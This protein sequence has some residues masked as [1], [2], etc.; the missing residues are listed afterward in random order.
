M[1]CKISDYCVWIKITE[2]SAI[3][4]DITQIPTA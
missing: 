2:Q 1:S 4:S 3:D